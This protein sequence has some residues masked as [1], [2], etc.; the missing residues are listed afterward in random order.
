MSANGRPIRFLAIVLGGWT[1]LRMAML[2]PAI[3]TP[4]DVIDAVLPRAA[5]RVTA[6]NAA[7]A[8]ESAGNARAAPHTSA[9]RWGT[10]PTA[11]TMR[12]P[13]TAEPYRAGGRRRTALATPG[14]TRSADAEP[15]SFAHT[16]PPAPSLPLAP[17]ASDGSRWSG[18]GWLVVRAGSNPGAAF[19]GSQLGGSQAGLRLAYTIDRTHRVAIAGRVSTPLSGD[20]R[21]VAIGVEWQPTRLPVRMIAEQRLS[22][23]GGRGGPTLG[24]IGGFG[25]MS[26]APGLTLEAYGQAGAIARDGIDA[27][28]DGAARVGHEL[29]DIG[30]AHVVLGAGAWGAAQRGAA[31]LDTGPS[32]SLDLPLARRVHAR[33]A[34]DWRARI[35]GDAR[36]GSGFVLTFGTDF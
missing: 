4:A 12:P 33:L 20:G 16:A 15:A 23:D 13:L 32:L 34:L 25:P 31:R 10:G 9:E 8:P 14:S 29:F 24:V 27:F 3:E 11:M 6:Q 22:L 17:R 2:W 5:A 21:E 35:A 28:A 36:P 19:G 7:I 1:V 26:V 30:G 18:S